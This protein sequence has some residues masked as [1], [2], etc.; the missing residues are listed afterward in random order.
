M[1]LVEKAAF[2]T[3]TCLL[4]ARSIFGL[5]HPFPTLV[6]A[7]SHMTVSLGR[8][9]VPYNSP[10]MLQCY[11]CYVHMNSNTSHVRSHQVQ[12]FSGHAVN[13]DRQP[14]QLLEKAF[15]LCYQVIL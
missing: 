12:L 14:G 13:Q 9:W 10:Y 4:A 1:L 3:V 7:R 2:A 15:G 6:T 5:S 11:I 8:W